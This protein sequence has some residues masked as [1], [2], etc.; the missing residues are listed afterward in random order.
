MPKQYLFDQYSRVIAFRNTLDL[1]TDR[2]CSLLA[3]S[4]LEVELKDLLK[5]CLIEDPGVENA[6]FSYNGPLGTF[7]SKIEMAF[8]LGRISQEVRNELHL[9]RKIRNQF[10]H[11][12][13]YLDFDTEAIKDRCKALMGSWRGEKTKPRQHFTASVCAILAVLHGGIYSTSHPKIHNFEFP[14]KENKEEF[15]SQIYEIVELLINTNK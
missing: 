5:K 2:G 1:E 11:S 14:Y 4:F 8:F 13:D 3:I 12:P 15:E 6:I 7:S 9:L 10:G